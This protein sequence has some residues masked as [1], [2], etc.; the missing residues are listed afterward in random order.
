M[1]KNLVI[2][3][4]ND[5]YGFL[6][7]GRQREIVDAY[8]NYDFSLGEMAENQGVTRQAVL[9]GLKKAESELLFLENKL[10]LY[11]LNVL[12]AADASKLDKNGLLRLLDE[13]RLLLTEVD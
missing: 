7:T 13:A 4:L 9:D 6:L 10:R 3:K 2:G 8:Y 5:I 11:R 1:E 12:L